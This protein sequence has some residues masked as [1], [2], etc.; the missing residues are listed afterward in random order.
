[1]LS[2]ERGVCLG[3]LF[4]FSLAVYIKGASVDIMIRTR[5]RREEGGEE[6][7]PKSLPPLFNTCTC[8]AFL[9]CMPLPCLLFPSMT[10]R[11]SMHL[12]SSLDAS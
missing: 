7:S 4:R 3:S 9:A 6:L 1:M 11:V 5:E 2:E 12:T 10:T 8:F